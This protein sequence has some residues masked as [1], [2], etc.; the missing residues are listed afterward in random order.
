VSSKLIGA[1]FA[2]A[3]TLTAAQAQAA[4]KTFDITWDS[5]GTAS[6]TGSITVDTSFYPLPVNIQF[7]LPNGLVSAFTMTVTGASS[8]N[9]TFNLSDFSA[10][11]FWSDQPLNLNTELMGQPDGL[12]CTF[13][14]SNCSDFNM[15]SND[16]NAPTGS[17]YFQMTT[18]GG[19]GDELD[20]TSIRP[21]A[22]AAVPEPASWA[23][24]MLGFGGLGAAL[25][26]TRRKAAAL[27]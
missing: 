8:G 7:F 9:G 12:G 15:T 1:A 19:T 27:A 17:F 25:R 24:L 5:P 21:A 11:T 16:P 2:A 14:M 3:L 18:S 20:V 23:L 26:S 22:G 13:G 4:M 6:A 10:I